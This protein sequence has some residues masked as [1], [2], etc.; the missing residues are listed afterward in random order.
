M[1][2][3]TIEPFYVVFRTQRIA[4]RGIPWHGSTKFWK[5]VIRTKKPR[6]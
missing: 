3:E 6:T 1:S 2:L 5:D 4:K